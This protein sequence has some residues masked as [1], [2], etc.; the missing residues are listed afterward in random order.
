[1]GNARRPARGCL[2]FSCQPARPAPAPAGR[3]R[4]ARLDSILGVF[5]LPGVSSMGTSVT[6]RGRRPSHFPTHVPGDS[7]RLFA[8]T[9]R[10]LSGRTATSPRATLVTR[11]EVRQ[12]RNGRAYVDLE[13]AD[14]S[15]NLSAK[16]WPDSPAIKGHFGDKDFV[17]FKARCA[18]S[19]TSCS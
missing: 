12:D 18:P 13:M 4:R 14:A 1:M 11:K 8:S 10:S 15:G 9:S 2:H 17:A 5:G 6:R 3:W 16:I 19:K 7:C